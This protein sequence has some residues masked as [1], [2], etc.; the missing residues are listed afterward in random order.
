MI[1][2]GDQSKSVDIE[3]VTLNRLSYELNNDFKRQTFLLSNNGL[4]IHVLESSVVGQPL[5]N[6][7]VASNL[8]IYLNDARHLS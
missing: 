7:R 2:A 1:I 3:H 5:N 8:S 4:A 6:I